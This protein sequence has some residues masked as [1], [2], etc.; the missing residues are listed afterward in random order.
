VT[1]VLSQATH[2]TITT[3]TPVYIIFYLQLSDDELQFIHIFFHS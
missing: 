2:H 1:R 3:L